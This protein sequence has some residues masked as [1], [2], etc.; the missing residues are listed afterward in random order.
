VDCGS[1]SR[2]K[3][4][5]L[6]AIKAD[7]AVKLLHHPTESPCTG[8][9]QRWGQG[10]NRQRRRPADQDLLKACPSPAEWVFKGPRAARPVLFV[11]YALGLNV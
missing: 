6:I 10:G 1:S 11:A 8:A 3:Q 2:E 9:S 7:F 4:L 5:P